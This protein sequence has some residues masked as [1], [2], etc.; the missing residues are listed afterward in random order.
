[1]TSTAQL[2]IKVRDKNDNAPHF[3]GP[4]S[5]TIKSDTPK[6]QKVASVFARDRDVTKPN[7]DV[8]YL[9]Q[10]G[11][12]GKFAVNYA[13]GRSPIS[14]HKQT[15]GFSLFID[16]CFALARDVQHLILE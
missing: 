2:V 5:F 9:L 1:M 13:T 11:G 7:Q 3:E 15:Y 10:E 4:R 12:N 6:G 8:I 14:L 16:R